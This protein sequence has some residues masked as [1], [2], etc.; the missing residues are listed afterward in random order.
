MFDAPKIYAPAHPDYY[1]VSASGRLGSPPQTAPSEVGRILNKAAAAQ[2]KHGLVI[3]MHGGLNGREYVL[4]DIVPRM[5]NFYLSAETY[6][7]FFVWRS[8]VTDS[9]ILNKNELLADPAFRELVKKVSEWTLKKEALGL[10]TFKGL[11][12]GKIND[13]HHFRREF[14]RFFDEEREAPPAGLDSVQADASQGKV[15]SRVPDNGKLATEIEAALDDDPAF[16]KAMIE[17]YNTSMAASDVVTKGAGST[18]KA[19]KG[20]LNQRAL[21]EMFPPDGMEGPSDS[22]LKSWAVLGWIGVARF[23]SKIVIAVIKRRRAGR[24]HGIYCTVVEEVLRCAYG[25]LFGATVWNQM[26]GDTY[27]SFGADPAHCGSSVIRA[28]KELEA[29]GKHFSQITLVGHSTG[30]IYICNFLDEAKT[31]GISTPIRVCFLAPAITC[32]R[33]A[34]AIDQHA[35]AGLKRFRMFAMND[36]L[37]SADCLVKPLYT[38]SLLY[39]V[40]GLLEGRMGESGWEDVVDMPIAGMQRFVENAHFS[41][42]AS[43]KKVRTFFKQEAQRCVWSPITDAG[44]GL[45]CDARKHGDFDD[46]EL[47]LDS[48]SDFIRS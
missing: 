9:L 22:D 38:R 32:E 30:A 18:N 45:N 39:F 47:T 44:V 43:V 17:A 23:V 19:L 15:K 26:K 40:S 12:G 41:D 4:S 48:L 1:L 34:V 28:I 36:E 13:V 2:P 33:F 20:L 27:D 37:E 11:A 31:Q 7:L 6:P 25:G 21:D 16:Q 3:H 42:E 29:Q 8:G 35:D 24:D 14:D 5:S 46:N 10:F